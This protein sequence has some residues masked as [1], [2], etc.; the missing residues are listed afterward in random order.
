LIQ[1]DLQPGNQVVTN[2][3]TG[4]E[5]RPAATAF[6]FGGQPQRG[7]FPGGGQGGNRGGSGGG[8]GGAGGR[9]R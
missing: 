1:G 5:T 3:S 9:G 4:S 2:V 8:A 6:P 7:G